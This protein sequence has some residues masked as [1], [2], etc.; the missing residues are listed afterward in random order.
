MGRERAAAR[1]G[2]IRHRLSRGQAGS[3][4]ATKAGQ[5]SRVIMRHAPMAVQNTIQP[6]ITSEAVKVDSGI[7]MLPNPPP[8]PPRAPAAERR[9]QVARFDVEHGDAHDPPL[10]VEQVRD[11][12]AAEDRREDQLQHDEEDHRHRAL[13]HQRGQPEA[14]DEPDGRLQRDPQADVDHQRGRRDQRSWSCSRRSPGWRPRRRTPGSA[15]A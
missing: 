7:S 14:D 12:V 6:T 8:P 11:D 5:A 13:P 3:D 1:L 2:R 10:D 15:P 9:R 4:P